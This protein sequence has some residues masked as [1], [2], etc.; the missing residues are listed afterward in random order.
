[1]VGYGRLSRLRLEGEP[2]PTNFVERT[3]QPNQSTTLELPSGI[4]QV[5]AESPFC[6]VYRNG[7]PFPL[8]I[9]SL[10]GDWITNSE[11]WVFKLEPSHSAQPLGTTNGPQGN[12]PPQFVRPIWKREVQ[13]P[14]LHPYA[15]FPIPPRIGSLTPVPP[16]S[17]LIGEG[18][19]LPPHPPGVLNAIPIRTLRVNPIDPPS[20]GQGLYLPQDRRAFWSNLAF[21]LDKTNVAP[22]KLSPP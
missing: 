9:P 16:V 5:R 3:I 12:S 2:T 21:S 11:T 10:G 15:R 20:S 17:P 4:Y 8:S 14:R 18:R 1:M 19:R 13:P 7:F 22:K 6:L